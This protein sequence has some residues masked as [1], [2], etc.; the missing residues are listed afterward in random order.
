MNSN[1]KKVT[2]KT[3]KATFPEE[4][5]S[6]E[7]IY[8][9]IIPVRK[10]SYWFTIPLLRMNVSA[11]T[12][13]VISMLIA[14]VACI[15]IALPNP[16]ARVV[17]IILVPV[18]H[19]F[20]CVDGNIA[21]YTKTASDFGSAVDAICGY[22]VDAYIPLSLGIAAYNVGIDFLGI[23]LHLYIILGGVAAISFTL[24]R[25]IHQKYAFE[26]LSVEVKTGKHFEKGDNQYTLTGF[27]KL[28]KVLQVN[29][30]VV[31]IPMFVLWLCPI[32]NL[33]CLLV[34][35]YCIFYLASLVIGVPFY[36]KKCKE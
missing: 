17:G 36:L 9:R 1:E 20:D 32:F 3:L 14:I 35:Y 18:W 29:C 6:V 28:R 24:M 34:I 19:I 23:P 4:K 26:A 27:H 12:A 30:S 11:F 13:S 5:K 2:Y 25:L 8:G 22:F 31:G 33:Y 7:S 10:I 16:I 21:R 15:L